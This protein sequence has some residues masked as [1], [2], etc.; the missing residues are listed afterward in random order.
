M[1]RPSGMVPPMQTST[2]AG[3]LFASSFAVAC[4]GSAEK[5]A[6]TPAS[7]PSSSP[8]PAADRAPLLT[9]HLVAALEDENATPYF[10]RRKDGALVVY[11]DRGRFRGQLIGAD[12]S[13]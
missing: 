4:G 2:V 8:K 13:A 5:A 1:G 9:A 12:G 6:R 3:L 7:R 11:S 10:A